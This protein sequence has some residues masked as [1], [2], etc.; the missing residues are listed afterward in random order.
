[1]DKGIYCLILECTAPQTIRIGALGER[2]FA[3]GWY[4]YV[5]SALGSGGLSRVSRH[6]RFYREQY[7]KPK[8]HIDYLMAARSTRLCKVVCAK[9]DQDLECVLA[10]ALGG[11]GIAA[12]GCSDC[13]CATHLFYRRDMPEDEVLQAFAQIPLTP[14]LHNLSEDPPSPEKLST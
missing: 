2:K 12:F 13:D 7:R 6:I 11:D 5:G 10:A 14:H 9:T 3:P 1:M 4:L 8:W